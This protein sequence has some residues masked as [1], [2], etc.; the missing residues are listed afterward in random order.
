MIYF[1]P[2]YPTAEI[3]YRPLLLYIDC[4]YQK[5]P[6]KTQQQIYNNIKNKLLY[7]ITLII[8]IVAAVA[9]TVSTTTTIIITT[10]TITTTTIHKGYK[11][12]TNLFSI[13]S[14]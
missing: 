10:I 3:K 6:K 11:K 8:T 2:V 7:K 14:A 13:S 12:S 9:T 5:N 1:F 4:I